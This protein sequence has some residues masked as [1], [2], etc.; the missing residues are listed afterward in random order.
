MKKI[1]LY[2][3]TLG[4]FFELEGVLGMQKSLRLSIK[5]GV[6]ARVNGF[7]FLELVPLLG[8]FIVSFC[9]DFVF[10]RVKNCLSLVLGEPIQIFRVTPQQSLSKENGG[11]NVISDQ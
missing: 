6:R 8:R 5:G 10:E 2:V 4:I 9:L 1:F 7:R 3:F 11:T